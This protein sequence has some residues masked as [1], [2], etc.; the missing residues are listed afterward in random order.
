MTSE[1]V[2]EFIYKKREQ[3]YTFEDIADELNGL[4]QVKDYSRQSVHGLYKRYVK[5][6]ALQETIGLYDYDAINFYCRTGSLRGTQLNMELIGC[7]ISGSKASSIL[8]KYR[9]TVANIDNELKELAYESIN[10]G[11]SPEEL[12]NKLSYKG[13]SIGTK[14]YERLVHWVYNRKVKEDIEKRVRESVVYNSNKK[15]AKMI[16]EEYGIEDSVTVVLNRLNEE[17]IE[18]KKDGTDTI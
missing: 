11:D 16:M 1:E 3:K 18:E 14:V 8:D 7:R 13:C 15:V 17:D 10:D 5:R 12:K 9:S 2:R 6:L 4:S